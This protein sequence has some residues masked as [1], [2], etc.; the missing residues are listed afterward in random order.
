MTTLLRRC[1]A[2]L[3]L[4]NRLFHLIFFKLI[5]QTGK[6][7]LVFKN[8][9][10]QIE[11]IE[12]IITHPYQFSGKEGTFFAFKQQLLNARCSRFVNIGIN[13]FKRMKC[14]NELGRPLDTNPLD[15]RNVVGTVAYKCLKIDKVFR[16][17]TKLLHACLFVYLFAFD[18]VI[19]D[20]L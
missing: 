4:F 11:R 12:D 17:D 6:I 3:R 2:C 16:T 5:N 20:Y 1:S 7:I 8:K 14:I 18:R 10:A 13:V 9:L 15:T 19:H